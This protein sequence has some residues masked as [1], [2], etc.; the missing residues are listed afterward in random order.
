MLRNWR[1]EEVINKVMQKTALAMDS[2]TIDCVVHAKANVRKRTATLQGGIQ[3]RRARLMKQGMLV[4]L[5][6]VWGVK[7]AIFVEKGTRP[8]FPPVEAIR[9]G[10][11]VTAQHAFLIARSIARKGTK[12]YPYLMPAA[13]KF[14]P[15]LKRRIKL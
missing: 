10:M 2:V 7:Y 14:Y 12:P 15:D 6:G 4:A 9:R 3:M 8:H 5:W 1:G 13:D 11:K